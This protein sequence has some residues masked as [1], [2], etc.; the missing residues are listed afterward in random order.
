MRKLLR[1]LYRAIRYGT[2]CLTCGNEMEETNALSGVLYCPNCEVLQAALLNKI[3][4]DLCWFKHE[5]KG[6]IPPAAEFLES[7]K[8]YHA[9]IAS[10]RGELAG[11]MTIA[12]LEQLLAQRT[13][14]RDEWKAKAE[15]FKVAC[16]LKLDEIDRLT[17]QLEQTEAALANCNEC[18]K[19]AIAMLREALPGEQAGKP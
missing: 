19:E 11:C 17:R 13:G 16:D 12:Q 3:G 6:K 2:P 5:D 18:S 10:E 8:R 15:A 7:C 14:E 1:R 9:Q 4:D